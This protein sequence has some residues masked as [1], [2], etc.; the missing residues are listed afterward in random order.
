[1][2]YLLDK[3]EVAFLLPLYGD[4]VFLSTV[5]EII[6]NVY[7]KVNISNSFFLLI[8]IKY[9]LKFSSKILLKFTKFFFHLSL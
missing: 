7:I 4:Y 1:M 3:K 6:A 2:S 9:N 5:I 8:A